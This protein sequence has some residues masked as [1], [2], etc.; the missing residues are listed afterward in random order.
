MWCRLQLSDKQYYSCDYIF[1]INILKGII[2][3]PTV[4]SLDLILTLK[5]F[6]DHPCHFKCFYSPPSGCDQPRKYLCLE[7]WQWKSAFCFWKDQIGSTRVFLLNLSLPLLLTD[8]SN[9]PRCFNTKWRWFNPKNPQLGRNTKSTDRQQRHDEDSC[10]YFKSWPYIPSEL[11]VRKKP[12]LL[13]AIFSLNG[14]DNF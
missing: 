6:D 13:S 5:I 14:S 9:S 10:A 11:Q 4:V 2:M 8:S 12:L 7:S 3:A 1:W